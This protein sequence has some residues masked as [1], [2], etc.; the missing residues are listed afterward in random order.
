MAG[1]LTGYV[2]EGV[3]VP[4]SLELLHDLI[5]RVGGDHPDV[6]HE[7]LFMLETAVIEIAGNLIEHGRPS[8]AVDYRLRLDVLPDRLEGLL[9]DSGEELP[10]LSP[11][12]E[13]DLLAEDGRGIFLAQAVLDELTYRRTEEANTWRMV[14]RRRPLVVAG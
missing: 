11:A 8:G 1:E 5:D 12:A 9:A 2:I 4:H 14:R 6:L 3:A 10:D 13:P 7:D